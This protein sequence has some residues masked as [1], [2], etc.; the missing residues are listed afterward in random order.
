[1]KNIFTILFFLAVSVIHAQFTLSGT[2]IDSITQKPIPY[3]LVTTNS[4]RQ[5]VIADVNGKFELTLADS[6][7]NNYLSATSMGFDTTTVSIIKFQNSG[8]EIIY[9]RH[10][11]FI[12]PE[13]SIA[14]IDADKYCKANWGATKKNK[15]FN[16]NVFWGAGWEI[17]TYFE[18]TNGDSGIISKIK[19]FIQDKGSPNTQFRAKLYSVNPK[20]NSPGELLLDQDLILQ[21]D[22]GNEWVTLD[23]TAFNIQI[24]KGGFF[25]AMEWLP[26][27]SSLNYTVSF[28]KTEIKGQGQVLG[29]SNE[30]K[31]KV[32]WFKPFLKTWR[33]Y[34]DGK[35]YIYNA[36]IGAEVLKKCK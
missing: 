23:I 19:F 10:K 27:C 1:M 20:K 33:M 2:I 21:G 9:L 26:A 34:E 11:Q 24:P 3:S 22:K 4:G 8:S 12:L 31:S 35:G 14:S 29:L 5:G 25:V 28:G 7:Q 17:A 18:N 36:M 6:L 15:T 16:G 30:I 13:V 32:T